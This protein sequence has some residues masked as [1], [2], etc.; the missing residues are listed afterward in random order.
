EQR[1]VGAAEAPAVDHADRRLLVPAQPLPPAIGLALRLAGGV[2]AFG[3]GHAEVFGQVHARRAGATFTGQDEH[4]HVVAEFEFVQ[5]LEHAAVELG[6]HAVALVGA[7]EIDPGDAVLDIIADGFRFG[8]GIGLG[9]LG[10][11]HYPR[12]WRACKAR[13]DRYRR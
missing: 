5:H 3:F 4:L 6:A 8:A 11:L 12:V 10:H 7:V 2:D 1:A 9:G 13:S